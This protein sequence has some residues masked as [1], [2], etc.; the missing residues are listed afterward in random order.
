[1]LG[2]ETAETGFAATVA[3]SHVNYWLIQVEIRKELF[4]LFC[5]YQRVV[6]NNY[7][8]YSL[9]D[10]RQLNCIPWKP[11]TV[12]LANN[13][14][15]FTRGKQIAGLY[16]ECQH[17]LGRTTILCLVSHLKYVSLQISLSSVS[18]LPLITA[19][20]ASSWLIPV[21]HH[22]QQEIGLFCC[23]EKHSIK[24]LF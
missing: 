22:S 12:I 23:S 18:S 16:D 4:K 11:M 9:W 7:I 5:Q 19:V 15:T 17:V 14:L 3:F 10:Y 20:L 2:K 1:M 21:H 13:V 8:L 24:W 6:V